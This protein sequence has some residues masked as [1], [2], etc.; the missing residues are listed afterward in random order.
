MYIHRQPPDK[1]INFNET[2]GLVHV[3]L[4]AIEEDDDD[5]DDDDDDDDDDEEEEEEEEEEEDKMKW[6]S[7]VDK[8][9]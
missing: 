3:F 4:A 6:G 7:R 5:N 9:Y 8:V 2:M 1:T